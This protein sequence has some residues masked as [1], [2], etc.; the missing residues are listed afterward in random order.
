MNSTVC[1]KVAYV[2][3]IALIGKMQTL[4]DLLRNV[5]YVCSRKLA[6][7]QRTGCHQ[8]KI[9]YKNNK[10]V[11]IHQEVQIASFEAIPTKGCGD[12]PLFLS[13]RKKVGS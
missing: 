8:K 11:P 12:P 4:S 9:N 13:A 3:G 10:N 5:I 1:G 7:S 6:L 2:N